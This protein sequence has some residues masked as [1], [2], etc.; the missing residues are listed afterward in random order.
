MIFFSDPRSDD[1]QVYFAH[2]YLRQKQLAC[3]E[4]ERGRRREISTFVLNWEG[5]LRSCSFL[6][7][8]RRSCSADVSFVERFCPTSRACPLRPSQYPSDSDI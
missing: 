4:S 1:L 2:V 6:S 7:V 3:E 8:K 5:V